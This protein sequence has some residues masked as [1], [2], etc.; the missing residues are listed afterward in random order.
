MQILPIINQV[1][2]LPL[3]TQF[4]SPMDGPAILV[5]TGSLWSQSNNV[6]LT[7]DVQLDGASIGTAQIFS[8]GSST[9]RAFS[10]LFIAVNLSYGPHTLVL[11][12]GAN[13]VS[14]L[15]DTFAVSLIF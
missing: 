1:G 3:K 6:M 10:T 9:H 2:P 13:T 12:S 8:N 11:I 7:M 5:V 4:N 14:D 15:N